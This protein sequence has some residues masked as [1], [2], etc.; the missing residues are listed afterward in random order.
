MVDAAFVSLD[1]L[2]T[3]FANLPTILSLHQSFLAKLIST[4]RSWPKDH[5][6][7]I[8]YALSQDVRPI[9]STYLDNFLMVPDHLRMLKAT[10]VTFNVALETILL[11]RDVM[12]LMSYLIA[13]VQVCV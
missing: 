9:Y 12:P 1:S 3:L 8:F 2:T 4:H 5:F 11:E 13:P 6:G 10:N 7:G